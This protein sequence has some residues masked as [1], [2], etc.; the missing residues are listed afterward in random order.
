[1]TQVEHRTE[2]GR[3]KVGRTFDERPT[4]VGRVEHSCRCGDGG[5]RR[6]TAAPRNAAVMVGS[7]AAR[8]VVAALV[9][10]ALQLATFFR[11]CCSNALDVATLLRWPATRWALQRCC[12]G[13]QRAGPRNMLLRCPATH[14]ASERCCD[15]RQRYNSG[16]R[17]AAAFLF[18]F[19]FFFYPTTLREKKNGKKREVLT[20]AL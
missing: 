8:N 12:D 1:M 14:W 2:V 17:C 4:K 7:V 9:D 19:L 15:V 6:Y 18:L 10:N 16:Q 20:P 11:R 13:Q 3:T 5:R